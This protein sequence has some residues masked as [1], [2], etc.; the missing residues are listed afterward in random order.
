M[1][2]AEKLYEASSMEITPLRKKKRGEAFDYEHIS[3]LTSCL[4]LCASRR[5]VSIAELLALLEKMG[6]FSVFYQIVDA[7]KTKS[8]VKVVNKLQKEIEK[9]L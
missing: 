3:F 7:D 9:R 8:K 6:L 4:S 2:T 5:G 1:C